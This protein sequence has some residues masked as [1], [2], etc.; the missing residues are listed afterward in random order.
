MSL[1]SPTKYFENASVI[2]I[3][4]FAVLLIRVFTIAL[5]NS[6]SGFTHLHKSCGMS[7]I[8]I[9]VLHS[10]PKIMLLLGNTLW[11]ENPGGCLW[12]VELTIPWIARPGWR[13]GTRCSNLNQTLQERLAL[14]DTLRVL[15]MCSS[16][17]VGSDIIQIIHSSPAPKN[18]YLVRRTNY[19]CTLP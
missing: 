8:A 9:Y 13:G 2:I 19:A 6:C 16:S 3:T 12:W 14:V 5:M 15:C 18:G 1:R 10:L 7:A 17:C 4:D 11:H